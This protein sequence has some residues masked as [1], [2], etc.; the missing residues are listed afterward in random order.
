MFDED[1]EDDLEEGQDEV[2]QVCRVESIVEIGTAPTSKLEIYYLELYSNGDLRI[3][4]LYGREFEKHKIVSM[5]KSQNNY[6]I[7]HLSGG[8]VNQRRIK[9]RGQFQPFMKYLQAKWYGTYQ[10]DIIAYNDN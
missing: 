2:K 8:S 5:V 9:F 1:R 10:S 4:S 6:Y 7:L 3:M